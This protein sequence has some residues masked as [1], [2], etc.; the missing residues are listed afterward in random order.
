M[1]KAFVSFIL[2]A[3]KMKRLLIALALCLVLSPVAEAKKVT[4]SASPIGDMV[5]SSSSDTSSG[6]PVTVCSYAHDGYVTAF[7][8][9]RK[10]MSL[11]LK[12][13]A[14]NETMDL[15]SWYFSR[16][17]NFNA[18]YRSP[19]FNVVGAGT[20]WTLAWTIETDKGKGRIVDA[21]ELASGTCEP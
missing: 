21:I 12:V 15:S 7:V 6:E 5:G 14:G 4:I 1:R 18:S 2:E 17:I 8:H 13:V 9:V 10:G 11:H 16:E 19:S 20:A 3:E